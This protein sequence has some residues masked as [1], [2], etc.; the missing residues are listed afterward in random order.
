M[1][2]F[3]KVKLGREPRY[4]RAREPHHLWWGVCVV[5]A[6]HLMRRAERRA[7]ELEMHSAGRAP[8]G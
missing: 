7:R 5:A 1:V 4:Q 2:I 8:G 3:S 6:G